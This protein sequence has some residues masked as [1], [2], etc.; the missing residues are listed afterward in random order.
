MSAVY[1][2]N[3]NSLTG[4]I[5][6]HDPVM[7]SDSNYY[8]VFHTGRGITIKRSED[9]HQWVDYGRVFL[10]EELPAWHKDDIPKQNGH[11]W[12]PDIH[13]RDG[14]YHLYYSV[15]AWMDFK[16][17]IGYATNT[18]LDKENP[19]YKWEDKGKVIDFRN[20]GE[21]VN[22]I[23]PNVFVDDDGRVWLY[24]GSYKAGLR[25]VE[26]DPVTGK[27]KTEDPEVIILTTGLGEGVY[28][29]KR[30]VYYYIFASRGI[31]CKGLDSNY[32]VVMGRSSDL[33]GPF[34]NREGESW[35]DNKYSLLLEGDYEEPGRGHN[36]FFTEGD[37]TFIVYHAYTRSEGGRPVMNIKPLF[38]DEKGWPVMEN[39]GLLF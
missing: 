10:Y 9:R 3:S 21:G 30:G 15:S 38:I 18:T 8:Y 28:L 23:D 29:L 33:H 6:V 31:C 4:D 12:A 22:V 20:G 19:E 7:I 1:A 25:L 39:T 14:K 32:Q 17:S 5:F 13:Y 16:S 36:G 11:L 35:V 26:L 24:Y 2:Q 34:L 37:T 27:L